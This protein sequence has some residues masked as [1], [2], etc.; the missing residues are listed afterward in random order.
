MPTGRPAG[1]GGLRPT[2]APPR[3]MQAMC[4]GACALSL[5]GLPLVDLWERSAAAAAAAASGMAPP[6]AAA[7]L[8]GCVTLAQA[9]GPGVVVVVVVV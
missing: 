8:S 3:S 1:V 6:P 5:D 2:L 4:R 7:K 9:R